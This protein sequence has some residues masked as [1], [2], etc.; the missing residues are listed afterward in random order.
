MVRHCDRLPREGVESTSLEL[1]KKP[2]DVALLDMG[3]GG[4]GSAGR[5]VGLHLGGLLQPE[6][7][8]GVEVE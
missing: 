1:F 2:A 8:C 7:F 4:L 5:M 3:F 6:Q